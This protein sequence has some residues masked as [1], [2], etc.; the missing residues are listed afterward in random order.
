MVVSRNQWPAVLLL[1]IL[2]LAT[3]L[4]FWH[5][6][7]LPPGLYHDEAYYGLDALSLL[8]GKLFPQYYE[9]WELYAGDAHA[10]NP[11]VPTRFPV[12]F[13]GN[14]GRE[15][16]HVYLVA[17]SIRIFGN[18]P[19]AVRVVTAAAGTLAVFTTWLAARALFPPDGRRLMNGELL[20][21]L[22]AFSLAVL[23]PALTFSRFGIRA[24]TLLP[25]MTLAVYAFWRGWNGRSNVW[26]GVAGFFTGLSLYTFAASRLFPVAFVLFGLSMLIVDRPGLRERWRGLA[27]ATGA[28]LLT[29]LPL[30]WYFIRYPYFFVF[31]MAFV[32]NRGAGVVEGAPALTWLLN[33]GR[34]I[35]GLFWKGDTHVRHNLPGRP[36]LDP[37]Q[38]LLLVAGTMRGARFF[39]QPAYAFV[40]F[41][42]GVML[43][44]SILSGDAPHFGRLVGLAPPA[45]ILIAIGGTWLS[46]K[47]AASALSS[48]VSPV[49]L[50]GLAAA[51]LTLTARDYFG[52]Y[53][54]HPDL[55]RDFY[56]ADWRLGQYAASQ[57]PE[58]VLYLSP[59][60]EEMATIYFALA[61]PNG[62]RSFNGEEGLI[63]AGIPEQP[64]V[65]LVRPAAE[66][67][68][69]S[70]QSYFPDG[71]IRRSEDN[72]VAFHVPADAERVRTGMTADSDFGDVIRLVGY[73]TDYS[74]DQVLI[75]LAWEAVAATPVNFTGFVHLLDANDELVAQ[76]DRP[77]V[78]Y[79]TSDWQPGEIIIDHFRVVLPPDLSPGTY[80]L[81]TGFY[82]PA[83][84][85][86]LGEA[87][88]LGSINLP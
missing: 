76:T 51:S 27:L 3:G 56:Q 69:S 88:D 43:L 19:F 84:V 70:L 45:A 50:V 29:A 18:I 60:Q 54:N 83:T 25:P 53:A 12:F 63:P 6:D 34:V 32:A 49:V 67:T 4:R 72:F 71:E 35:G 33:V 41:W 13:E 58:T 81:R 16:L 78:G 38:A 20:P 2:L 42:F 15:P 39:R 59:S 87:A 62:I 82:D 64:A 24:M 21:L 17:L 44:P 61:D 30:L 74:D 48:W 65:Y 80:R 85:V 26:L 86:R 55:S 77:P 79:P 31:R 37:V 28:A 10:D 5:L 75:T 22:A 11:A 66:T 47:I 52:R 40:L 46:E 57:P 23:Y 36:Y 9:G 73:T 68:L 7:R 1:V 8:Q 14:Y